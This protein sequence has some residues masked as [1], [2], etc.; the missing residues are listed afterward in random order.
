MRDGYNP[1][2]AG[3]FGGVYV[4]DTTTTTGDWFKLKTIGTS[5]AVFQAITSNIGLPAVW[6][7]KAGDEI[8]GAFQSFKLTSGAVVA[9]K[10]KAN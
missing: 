6:T 9:Y 7:L 4:A 8:V 3:E 5:D 2:L 1:Q 10:R